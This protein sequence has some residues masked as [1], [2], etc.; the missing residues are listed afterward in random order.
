VLAGR[1]THH[2]ERGAVGVCVS[3]R[4]PICIECS[5]PMAGIHRCARCVAMMA[6]PA[7]PAGA[8]VHEHH[9]MVWLLLVSGIVLSTFAW[10]G[11]ALILE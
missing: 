2:P 11:L 6:K 10:A 4:T 5:T 7:A 1:C 3:C 9:P 8:T